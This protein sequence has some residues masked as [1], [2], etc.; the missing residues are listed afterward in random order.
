MTSATQL[1]RHRPPA[2]RMRVASVCLRQ[3]LVPAGELPD[4]V[5]LIEKGG[6]RSLVP[7]PPKAIGER[8][9]ATKPVVWWAGWG[10]CRN[11]DRASTHGRFHRSPVLPAEQFR[12]LWQA[13]LRHWCAAQAPAAE[14]VDLALQ[15]SHA[16]PARS[17]QLEGGQRWCS[18]TARL[19][20]RWV[21]TAI[22]SRQSA[23]GN[24]IGRMARS[25]PNDPARAWI[26]NG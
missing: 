11:A 3:E 17:Q 22:I 23:V 7:L 13:E 24:G 5:W 26:R 12:A 21:L 6:V 2:G 9:S 16:N 25:G 8:W 20:R 1:H 4:G 18:S 19:D 14:V 10:C 15:L